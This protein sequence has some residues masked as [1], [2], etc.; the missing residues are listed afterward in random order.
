MASPTGVSALVAAAVARYGRLD[1]LLLNHASVDDRMLVE[2]A[3]GSDVAAGI[4]AVMG[5]NLVGSATAVAAALPHLEAT[6]GHIA[7]VSSASAHVPAPFH[8]AYVA[9]KRALNGYFETVRHELSLLGSRV[10]LGIQV[11]GMIGTPE[12]MKDAGNARLA[13]S[14]PQC[15]SEMICAIQ[16]R[17]NT[18]FVPHVRCL[19]LFLRPMIR[20]RN[21]HHPHTPCSGT[22]R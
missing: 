10:T 8:P 18:V 6:A 12:I 14:V 4:N 15:A 9:S 17:W 7:I 1:V 19:P 21:T 2:Y 20:R 5:A 22:R 16:A 13:I 3:N 11:L